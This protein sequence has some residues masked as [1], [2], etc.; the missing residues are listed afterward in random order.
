MD[1]IPVCCISQAKQNQ[2]ERDL[3]YKIHGIE[4]TLLSLFPDN[5]RGQIK[6]NDKIIDMR[7]SRR[8]KH[9]DGFYMISLNESIKECHA[10]LIYKET[11]ADERIRYYIYDSNGQYW[12]KKYEYE[13]KIRSNFPFEVDY[14]MSP[15]KSINEQA[16]CAVWCIVVIS[17]WNSFKPEDRTNALN[18]F[19]TKMRESPK[20]RNDFLE[21]IL[22]LISDCRDTSS[23]TNIRQFVQD[24][25]R[26]I[27]NLTVELP[28]DI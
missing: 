20:I 27:C 25:Y 5:V 28:C 6:V 11:I 26:L 3:Q 23:E 12:A 7:D 9:E 10:V 15:I 21:S 4:T 1:R 22:Q 18:I 16:K 17:L 8:Y 2:K 14:T 19:N 24:V 13:T